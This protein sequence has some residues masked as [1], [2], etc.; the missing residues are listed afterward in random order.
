VSRTAACGRPSRRV[1]ITGAGLVS[2]LGDTPQALAAALLAGESGLRP[3]TL[4]ETA[5]LPCRQ[6]GEVAP[7]DEDACFGDRNL[8][9]LDRIGKLVIAAAQKALD[10]SGWTA[11]LRAEREVGLVLGTM[12]CGVHTI[13]EFDRRGLT[14]GPSY[15]SPLD[16]ANTVIN[17]AAGQTGIWHDLRGVNSTIAG[18]SASGLQAIAYAAGLIRDGRAEALLAGGAE[19]LCEEAFV[20]FCRTGRLCGAA[21]ATGEPEVPVPFAAGRNGFA[22]AEGAALVVLEEAEAAAARGARLLAEVAGA[23]EAFD[24]TRGRNPESAARAVE[25]ALR[26]ALAE[27]C[28]A[29]GE[30]GF[31]SASANG[32]PAGDRAEAEGVARVWGDAAAA[33]PVTAVKALLGEAL[34]ASGAFQVIAALAALA[35]GELPGVAGL[36]APDPGLPLRPRAGNRPIAARACAVDAVGFDGPCCALVLAV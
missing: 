34:G 29:P 22:L 33:L 5:G 18:G 21:G 10:D 20:G 36:T 4:F 2:P 32:S 3:I 9:P 14:R 11:E 13:A 7:F 28:L 15:V 30:I 16:F 1:V 23:G 17:A 8:R 35:G 12:F 6:A 19:E 25:R 26:A 31:L 27:A 24:P